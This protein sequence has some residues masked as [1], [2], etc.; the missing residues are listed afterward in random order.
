MFSGD[1]CGFPGSGAG[2]GPRC[3]GGPRKFIEP[4]L[5][6]FLKERT[7]Y[8]YEL[9]EMFA[10]FGFDPLPDPGAVYRNLRRMEE[11]GLVE[12]RWEL[13]GSGLPR[14]FYRLTGEGDAVLRAW[15]RKF[16]TNRDIADEFINYYRRIAGDVGEKDE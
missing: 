11:E 9:I 5:L 1:G 13:E 2:S 7:A 14:R 10:R 6:L 3:A 8:G 16:K 4:Y 12:S 15:V